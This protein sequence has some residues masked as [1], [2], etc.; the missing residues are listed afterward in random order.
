MAKNTT[1]LMLNNMINQPHIIIIYT[2]C[3]VIHVGVLV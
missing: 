3:R 1:H 2:A